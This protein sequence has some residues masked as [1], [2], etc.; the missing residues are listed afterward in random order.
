MISHDVDLVGDVVNRVFY[1]DANRQVLDIYNMGWKQ[2]LKQR[3]ADEQ[4]RKKRARQNAEKKAGAL[5]LQ[6]AKMRREGDA[7]RSP[8]RTWSRR[9]ERLLSGL[10]EVRQV[11]RVAKLRFPDP[12]ALRQDAA[13]GL[14]PVEVLRLARDLL[15]RRPRDRPRLEGRR[16]RPERRRQDHP[17][18]DPRRRRPARHRADRARATACASATTRRSTR[19]ST[20]SAPCSRTWSRAAPQ[21]HRDRGAPGARLVPLHRATTATSPPA[22]SP[23]ARRPG[24]RSRCSSSPAPTCCCSTSRRTTSTRP[25]ARRS[26]GA[27]ELRGRRGAGQP[28]RG[29][30]RGAEPRARA[31]HAGRH[32]GPLEPRLRGADQRQ[33]TPRAALSGRRGL[34]LDRLVG[35]RA[36]RSRAPRHAPR[37]AVTTSSPASSRSRRIGPAERAED[38]AARTGSTGSRTRGGCPRRSRVG[39]S[40]ARSAS[41]RCRGGRFCDRTRPY[42]PV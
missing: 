13:D 38:R 2:Y 34:V 7:R 10:E 37:A 1:L 27:R 23:A 26:S 22:C 39:G 20:S 41:A 19:P 9:A 6:A 24:S 30:R 5:Q 8:R 21:P 42:A 28:R 33:L 29:R 16:P 11:D 31:H 14:R 32:R 35:G 12:G 15:R 17:A 18:A 36:L 25:A 4:R 3:E 40:A